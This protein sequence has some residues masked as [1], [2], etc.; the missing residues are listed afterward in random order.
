MTGVIVRSKANVEAGAKTR[1]STMLHGLWLLI[2]ISAFPFAL[3]VV[4]IAAL[5][6]ILVYTGFRLLDLHA[7]KELRK[8]GW[9]EV[10]I[11]LATM[12]CVVLFGLLEGVLIGSALAMAKLLWTFSHL[13]IR[14]EEDVA[15]NRRV[16]Y[17]EGAATFIRLP[18]LA[19]ALEKVPGNTELHV[20][21]ER[22]S[23]IDHACLEL[24]MSWEKQHEA[25]GGS[26]VMDWDSLHA[27]F[28]KEPANG[29]AAE[30]GQASATPSDKASSG[31]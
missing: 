4:P 9:S 31:H 28:R 27:K 12:V 10:F 26:L 21:M 18:V 1:L 3:Q 16:M 11:Y 24:L 20:H 22:L 13:A 14:V 6:A 17:L 5:A 7:I 19:S 29:Q 2:F 30:N 8:V 23:Y 15:K 25:T